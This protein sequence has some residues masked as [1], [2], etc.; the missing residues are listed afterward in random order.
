[1][2]YQEKKLEEYIE[3]LK[4]TLTKKQFIEAFK[5]VMEQI[6]RLEQEL[7][8][9]IDAKTQ[10]ALDTLAEIQKTYKEVIKRIEEENK[11][12]FSNMK[13]WAIE[14]VNTLFIKF[15]IKEKI[16]ELDKKMSEIKDGKDADEEKI[17]ADVLTQIKLP[18][19][20][21]FEP[22]EIR[23]KLETLKGKE[24]LNI[25]AIF[26]LQ[27]KLDELKKAGGGRFF[28]G[29]GF[30]Y[31]ALNIHLVDDETPTGTV[32]GANTDFIINHIPSPANSLKV[33]VGG[34]RLRLTEDYT[35]ASRTITF[36]IAPPTGSIILCDY[37][38]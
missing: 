21:I 15:Q 7:I 19:Q 22:E 9:K 37:R 31:D 2:T 24:K 14:Q 33:Y 25:D 16:A 36:L 8:S 17:V 32:D 3:L 30:N 1:M 18:E 6:K 20:K 11:S 28:G 4:E 13:K 12:S 35:L 29:G 26:E 38:I 23:D 27:E 5:S 10:S 34:Q